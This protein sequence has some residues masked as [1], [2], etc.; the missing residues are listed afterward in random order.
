MSKHVEFIQTPLYQILD[1]VCGI[2]ADSSGRMLSNISAEYILYSTFLKLTGAQEQKLK[3]VCWEIATDNYEFRYEWLSGQFSQGECSR[4]EDKNKILSKLLTLIRLKEDSFTISNTDK[5]TIVNDVIWHVEQ[6][7]ETSMV[8]HTM[9]RTHQ[10]EFAL[11]KKTFDII[12]NNP[13]IICE[14][15]AS[16]KAPI[17][18]AQKKDQYP[19]AL[20]EALPLGLE[21]LY[22]LQYKHRNRC[23]HNTTSYQ[24]TDMALFRNLGKV[25]L[26]RYNYLIFFS[27]LLMID[28][29]TI[30][31][32]NKYLQTCNV[33]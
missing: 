29:I 7:Y 33:E 9:N 1:E 15:T 27:L 2:L 21:E 10:E 28:D 20:K 31:L 16:E 22:L 23:A 26:Y 18:I 8:G 24:E 12:R 17:K 6:F 14:I 30:R 25:D 13:Q 19:K 3:C 4:L 11:W 5:S 32:Y